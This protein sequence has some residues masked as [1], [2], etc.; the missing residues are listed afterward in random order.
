L[1]ENDDIAEDDEI[2]D[3][4]PSFKQEKTKSEA[5]GTVNMGSVVPNPKFVSNN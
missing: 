3:D 5:G 2:L 1:F 4:V